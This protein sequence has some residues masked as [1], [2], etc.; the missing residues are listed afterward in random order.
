MGIDMQNHNKWRFTAAT[1]QNGRTYIISYYNRYDPIKKQSRT[2]QKIHVGRLNPDTGEVLLS[3]NFLEKRPE[4]AG[5]RW[6]Y[7]DNRLVERNGP[8]ETPHADI[9]F[10]NESVSAG[11]TWASWMM[12]KKRFILED[13]AFVFGTENA[14]KMLALAIYQMDN[15]S[16]M[17][18]FDH[19]L[20]MNWL[21]DIKPMS[22][23]DISALLGDINQIKMD[24]Y[25]KRRYERAV[26]SH[27]QKN[28]QTPIAL[29][30]DSTSISTYSNTID[31]AAF[32]HA[33]SDSHLRQINLSLCTDYETGDVCYA[34]ESEGSVNDVTLFPLLLHRMMDKGLDLSDMI[35]V[36]DRGYA[37]LHNS[38]R[39][40][41]LNLKFVQ[42]VRLSENSIKNHFLKYQSSFAEPEFIDP[43]LKTGARTFEENWIASTDYGSIPVKSYLHLYKDFRLELEQKMLLLETVDDIIQSKNEKKPVEMDLYNRYRRFIKVDK[44]GIHSRDAVKIRQACHL[45]G[46]FAI[47]SNAISDPFSA[48]RLYRL[49]NIAEIGFNQFKN[50]TS[51]SRLYSTGKSYVGKLFIHILAQSL[52][53]MMLMALKKEN[54][55]Y[56]FKNSLEN[57]FW[58]L[59]KLMAEKPKGR[60]AWILKEIPKK[61]RDLFDILN[62]P[63]PPKIIRD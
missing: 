18:H 36:T 39:L 32:G 21:A 8:D 63:T 35:I 58:Q 10:K 22:S 62:I 61:T 30:L 9:S 59:R 17:M 55:Q 20:F 50:H 28:A 27:K 37:S 1:N 48:L 23:Q 2:A 51:G 34:Y 40:H 4:F 57:A 19:W 56:L 5:K 47:R 54:A 42:G 38:Q 25:F 15:G 3:K 12:A 44:K 6:F 29:A 14:K 16:A 24:Q 7:E 43:K 31:N 60:N 52:R 11:L 13:L 45:A 49:R 53:M 46:C 33:K 26:L 41:N